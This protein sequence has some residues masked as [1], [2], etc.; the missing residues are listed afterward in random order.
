ML[1]R[2]VI[3]A[4][5]SSGWMAASRVVLAVLVALLFSLSATAQST[6]GRI[7]GTVTDQSGA[8]VA[9]ATVVVTDIQRNTSRT[10]STDDTGSY[11]A[12]DLTPGS[13]K[14]RVEAKGFKSIER[15]NVQIEVATDVRSDFS[16]AAR[17]SHRGDDDH[18]RGAAG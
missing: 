5:T 17:A 1:T 15:P 11:V 8:A 10:L 12:A 3:T 16:S 4:A 14:V 9:G 13:Y 7:L 18:G 2:K 6:A